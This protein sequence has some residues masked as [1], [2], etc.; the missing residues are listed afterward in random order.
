MGKSILTPKQ[1][2][3]LEFISKDEQITKRFYFTGGSALAEFYLQHRLS[4]DIDLFT[5]EEEVNQVAISAF[6]EK[7][8]P[9]LDIREI[10]PTQFMGLFSYILIFRDSEQLKVDFN[11]YPFP[12]ISR[13]KKYK[14]L[15]IDSIYDIVV[16]K[17]QTMLTRIRSRDFIDLYFIMKQLDY[18]L[19][20]LMKDARSKFDWNVDRVTLASQFARVKEITE[21]PTMLKEFKQEKMEKFYLNLIKSLEGEIFK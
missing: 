6:L 9:K 20:Q 16:N 5:E 12:R 19:D 4:E 1:F 2:N 21:L 8:S 18:S 15:E 7:V 10:K 11:Y 17:V 13:G 14:D 3:F